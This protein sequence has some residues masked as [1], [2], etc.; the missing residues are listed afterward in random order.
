MTLTIEIILRGQQ[1]A[2]KA[3]KKVKKVSHIQ[4]FA[5]L[6]T[7]SGVGRVSTRKGA[8]DCYRGQNVF[9]LLLDANRHVFKKEMN[10]KNET[11]IA[12]KHACSQQQIKQ[13]Y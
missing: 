11:K 6:E 3:A 13:I 8:W 5:T 4:Q 12:M 1:S 7:S 2:R 9:C 10:K